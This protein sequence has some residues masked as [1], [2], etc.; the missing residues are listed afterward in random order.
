[1]GGEAGEDLGGDFVGALGF[2][3]DVF[4][5]K[6][7]AAA[8]EELFAGHAE[9]AEEVAVV[10][11]VE[12]AL[13]EFVFGGLDPLGHAAQAVFEGEA[14]AVFG[15]FPVGAAVAGDVDGE[16]GFPKAQGGLGDAKGG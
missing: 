11:E 12:V 15:V 8:A 10:H 7:K 4:G 5:S 3:V 1:V 14:D 6:E 9:E 2:L 16:V 13:F